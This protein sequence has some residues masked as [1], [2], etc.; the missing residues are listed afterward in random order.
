VAPE[1]IAGRL[2][3]LNAVLKEVMRI[4]PTSSTGME[5]VVP[6]GGRMVAGVFLPGCSLVSVPIAAIHH[7]GSI[8]E[9]PEKFDPQRWL[10]LEAKELMDYYIPFSLG[11]RGCAGRPFAMMEMCK[12]MATLLRRYKIERMIEG[13]SEER[14]GFIVKITECKVR[15]TLR[16]A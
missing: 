5:R 7:D 6:E 1:E 12:T 15:I 2:P 4:R 14:E 8:F 9:D 10:R 11:S 3:L 16:E 13:P